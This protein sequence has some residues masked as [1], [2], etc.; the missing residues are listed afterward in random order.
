MALTRG[1]FFAID[2]LCV[3][4]FHPAQ[5]LVSALNEDPAF[6]HG[7]I[8]RRISDLA[9]ERSIDREG[10]RSSNQQHKSDTQHPAEQPHIISDA[11]LWDGVLCLVVIL[12]PKM[13]DKL[14]ATQMAQCVFELHQLN[15]KIMLR[16][17][18]G[19]CHR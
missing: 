4:H 15:E 18:P 3:R 1:Y 17:K 10:S 13:G 7:F 11:E 6:N 19:H 2:N 16:V 9:A 5:H 14:L 8:G 12:E